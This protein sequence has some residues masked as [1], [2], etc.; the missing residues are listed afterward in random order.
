MKVLW[1][2][3]FGEVEDGLASYANSL[4]KGFLS[5][6]SGKIE[7]CVI[8]WNFQ[9]K[10]KRFLHPVIKIP[11]IFAGIYRNEVLHVQYVAGAYLLHLVL[12]FLWAKVLGRRIVVTF[13]ERTKA[14]E[15]IFRRFLNNVHYSLVDVG[16][17]HSKEHLN[18]VPDHW[19]TKFLHIPHMTRTPGDI[20]CDTD[21][22]EVL[23][24]PGFINSWKGHEVVIKAMPQIL[25]HKPECILSIQGKVYDESYYQKLIG[26]V[27]E[28]KLED[29][30][31]FKTAYL[32]EEDYWCSI[33]SATMVL[34]PYSSITMSGVLNDALSVGSTLVVSELP[35][36]REQLGCNGFY[37]K[38]RDV[39]AWAT[40]VID[41]FSDKKSLPSFGPGGRVFNFA[42]EQI[43]LETY[44]KAYG[45]H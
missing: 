11:S 12:P 15:P 38:N 4:R 43:A 30:V 37:V 7:V 14:G 16:I 1:I 44:K 34:L 18:S 25:K 36:F 41:V 20:R 27:S 23:L 28:L 32:S 17:V 2:S 24:I 10:V 19:R 45:G 35:S 42:P 33:K 39:D 40:T 13:H 3:P 22:K 5:S 21:D 29:S 6:L 8:A 9:K 26:L 31:T